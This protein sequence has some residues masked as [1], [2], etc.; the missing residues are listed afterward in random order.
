MAAAA[1]DR[2]PVEI[3]GPF[4]FSLPPLGRLANAD[5]AESIAYLAV[6]GILQ[7][8]VTYCGLQRL[9]IRVQPGALVK[10]S[11]WHWR[12]PAP[13]TVQHDITLTIALCF[14]EYP[15]LRLL[16]HMGLDVDD[17]IALDR[18]IVV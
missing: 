4:R 17:P 16:H 7:H 8:A 11:Q 9:R 12:R 5:A 6:A 3:D 1:T 15:P 2:Q 13:Y 18:Y 14:T 10:Q